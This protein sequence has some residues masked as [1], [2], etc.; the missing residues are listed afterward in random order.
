MRFEFTENGCV[1]YFLASF[2]R[3]VVV[4]DNMEGVGLINSFANALGTYTN[5]LAQAAH[6]VG[7]RSGPYG[8][9]G[10]VLA[11]LALREVL[12]SLLIK[13]GHFTHDEERLGEDAARR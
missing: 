4:V 7:V 1:G 10:W 6:L 5:S 8:R 9:K 3:D 12:A 2:R 13:D 11:E